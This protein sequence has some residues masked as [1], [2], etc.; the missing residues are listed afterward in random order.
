MHA[1]GANLGLPPS[2]G[3]PCDSLQ[4]LGVPPYDESGHERGTRELLLSH[5]K[6]P[7]A[8]AQVIRRLADPCEYPDGPGSAVAVAEQLPQHGASSAG[9]RPTCI[10]RMRTQS[11]PA[12]T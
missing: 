6:D 8:I 11:P 5:R 2:V 10:T 1:P 9:T 4:E 3:E 7:A 12:G